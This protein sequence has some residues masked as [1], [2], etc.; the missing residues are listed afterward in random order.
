M[1]MLDLPVPAGFSPRAE[2]F[3]A[4]A[5]AGAIARFQVRPGG[6]LV[7]L[8]DLPPGRP[9]ELTYHLRATMPVEVTAPGARAY[10]YYDPD[11]QG[12]S[13]PQRLTVKQNRTTETRSTGNRK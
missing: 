1:V 2:H 13:P 11:R 9:L 7:Y 5:Q 8:R 12:Q 6:V 4:L 3:A 10:E